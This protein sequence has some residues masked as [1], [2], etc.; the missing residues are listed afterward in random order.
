MQEP[1]AT[2]LPVV[3]K[4]KSDDSSQFI[5]GFLGSLSFFHYLCTIFINTRKY[6][7]HK[8]NNE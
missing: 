2:V 3:K 5:P 6:I 8:T 4:V 1:D 7:N